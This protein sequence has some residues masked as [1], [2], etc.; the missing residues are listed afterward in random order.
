MARI[1]KEKEWD[2]LLKIKTSGRD[3]S[4]SNTVNY[5]YEPTDYVILERFANEG[6]VRKNNTLL[7]YGCG[8]WRVGFFM[9]QIHWYRL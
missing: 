7:D 6:Y 8:K 5:P 9:M 3:D 2:A 4:I 1:N